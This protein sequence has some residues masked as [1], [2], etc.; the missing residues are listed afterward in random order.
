M[1]SDPNTT[2][3]RESPPTLPEAAA[4]LTDPRV[5]VE[6]AYHSRNLRTRDELAAALETEAV[7]SDRASEGYAERG[8]YELAAGER[9]RAALPS[10]A[11]TG[12]RRVSSIGLLRSRR[13]LLAPWG[14]L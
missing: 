10:A 5:L 2:P 6:L 1:N 9:E 3:P 4:L 13:T 11:G 7:R 14:A 12:R 8:R